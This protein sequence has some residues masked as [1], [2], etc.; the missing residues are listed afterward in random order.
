LF[1][2]CFCKF[3]YIYFYLSVHKSNES[4]GHVDPDY[5][6]TLAMGT[7]Q[8]LVKKKKDLIFRKMNST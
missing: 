3:L 8:G 4:K 5:V 1:L 2:Q 6:R 7:G